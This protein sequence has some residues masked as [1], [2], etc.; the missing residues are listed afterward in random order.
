MWRVIAAVVIGYLALA[1][2]VFASFSGAYLLM[3]ADRAFR[4]GSY[5]VSAAWVATSI[6]LGLA[7]AVVGGWV[8]ARIAGNNRRAVTGLA[9]LVLVLGL[10]MAIPVLTQSAGTNSVRTG[11]VPN[12][13]AMQAAQQPAW[14][15]LLNPV[16]GVIGVLLGGRLSVRR[17]APRTS[18]T[19]D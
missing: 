10:L 15:A 11:D 9:G 12:M 19:P 16:I 17:S 2:L 13:R 1:L 3:G 18:S 4:P 5:Q 8:A 6:L 14:V 7:A